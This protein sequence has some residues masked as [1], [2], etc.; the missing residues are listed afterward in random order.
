[1]IERPHF[2]LHKL[3]NDFVNKVEDDWVNRQFETVN[4]MKRRA[5]GSKTLNAQKEY[6]SA[7]S[8]LNRE[9]ARLT[10]PSIN[11]YLNDCNDIDHEESDR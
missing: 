3:A 1:M 7:N 5:E 4:Q 6:E 2:D 11:D 10:P 8:S 9:I